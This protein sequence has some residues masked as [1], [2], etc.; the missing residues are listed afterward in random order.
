MRF[1][2][3]QHSRMMRSTLIPGVCL[4]PVRS[5]FRVS[6]PLD[7]FLPLHPSGLVS[8]RSRSW[9]SPLQSFSLR[10][11]SSRL[12]ALATLLTLE[13]GCPNGH[14]DED[15]RDKRVSSRA[16]LL[17]DSCSD[18]TCDPPSGPGTSPESVSRPLGLAAGRV[19]CSLG[20]FASTGL[21][22][23]QTWGCCFQHPSSHE[24]PRCHLEARR[25][26]RST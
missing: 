2:P 20:V 14:R 4:A 22:A 25:K 1:V 9:G 23:N 10:A 11:K 7:G 8:C 12:S 17:L 15:P 16:G 5:A 18:A 24:L 19:R 26:R 21:S 3:L 6:R 13:A